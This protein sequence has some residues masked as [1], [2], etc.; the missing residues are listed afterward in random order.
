M[1]N[2]DDKANGMTQTDPF[3]VLTSPVPGLGVTDAATVLRDAFGLQGDLE[4]LT[5]ER[6]QNFR[7]TLASGE[8]FVLK[9][10]NSAEDPGVTD[11]QSRAMLHVGGAADSVPVPQVLTTIDGDTSLKHIAPDG[12]EHVIRVLSW[13]DG[14]PLQH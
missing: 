3:E 4:P 8:R 13:L 2:S 9:I 7:V 1:V 12:R 11:L 5:S 6:D 10:A 14:V